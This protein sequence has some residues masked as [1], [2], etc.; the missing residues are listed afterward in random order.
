M[1]KY[2]SVEKLKAYFESSDTAT[3]QDVMDKAKKDTNFERMIQDITLGRV[4]GKGK[5]EKLKRF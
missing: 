2:K 1:S 4:L 3:Y 5:L